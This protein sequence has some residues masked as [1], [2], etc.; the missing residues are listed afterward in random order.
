M[1]RFP[2]LEKDPNGSNPKRAT[3]IHDTGDANRPNPEKMPLGRD[4][5]KHGELCRNGQA[6]GAREELKGKSFSLPLCL[7]KKNEHLGV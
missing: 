1:L 6:R 2:F 7:T 3:K 5:E 4:E